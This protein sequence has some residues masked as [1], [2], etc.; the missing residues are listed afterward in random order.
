VFIDGL[1]EYETIVDVMSIVIIAIICLA[2]I[3]LCFGFFYHVYCK[4]H[5]ELKW[6]LNHSSEAKPSN[7]KSVD[8]SVPVYIENATQTKDKPIRI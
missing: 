1:I 6:K 5:R 3:P 4:R 2:L 8:L 7:T